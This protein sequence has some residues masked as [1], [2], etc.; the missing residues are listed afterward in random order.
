MHSHLG[1]CERRHARVF[2]T[3]LKIRCCT[4][5][6]EKKVTKRRLICVKCLDSAI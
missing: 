5:Y 4:N 2:V 1:W 6:S 3:A